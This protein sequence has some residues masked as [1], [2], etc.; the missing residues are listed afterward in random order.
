MRVFWSI[1]AIS[2][3]PLQLFAYNFL[4]TKES[5]EPIGWDNSKTIQYYLDPGSLG[6]YSNDQAHTLLKEAMKLWKNVSTANIKFEFAGYLPEDVNKDNY[7][8]YVELITCLTENFDLCDNLEVHQDLKT[9]IIFDD[10]NYILDNEMC[11]IDSCRARAGPMTFEGGY[12]TGIKYI[13]QGRAVFGPSTGNVAETVTLFAHELGHLLG[14]TH[15]SLNQQLEHYALSDL[16]YL[17]FY[18]TME[19]WRSVG[20]GGLIS[21]AEGT[22]LNVDDIAGI[23]V[24]YPSDTFYQDTATIKGTVKKSDGIPMPEVNI[25]VRDVTDPLCKAYSFITSRLC[26]HNGQTSWLCNE[27]DGQFIISGLQ[28]GDYTVEVEEIA[29]D[30]DQTGV[31]NAYLAGDAEF[32]NEGDQA[33]EDPYAYTVISLAAGETREN[34]DIILNRSEVT[35]GRI[36]YIPLDVILANFPLPETTACTDTTVDYAGL[37]GIEETPQATTGGCALIIKK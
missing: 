22:T 26:V 6:S 35:E 28:P 29:E 36:K 33:S 27:P 13:V 32:W 11:R 5:G 24:L 19:M 37:I 23:S 31:L 21:G 30:P 2:I 15:P 12:S 1:I 25:V 34:V 10:D 3:I 17:L 4:E 20:V 7:K 18:P 14:L 9:V 16:D 8:K